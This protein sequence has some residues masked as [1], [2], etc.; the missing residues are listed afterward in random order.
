MN[1]LLEL[2]LAAVAASLPRSQQD[3]I[4]AELRDLLLTKI[5]AREAALGRALTRQEGE[6]LLNDFGHPLEVAGR[7]ARTQHLIGPAIYPFYIYGLKAVLAIVAAIGVIGLLL[8]L[9]IT[10]RGGFPVWNLAP[11]LLIA[12]AAVTLTS[13]LIE[14]FGKGVRYLRP[15]RPG[16]FPSPAPRRG[17]K[18]CN[19]L[20]EAALNAVVL[21]WWVSF[22]THTFPGVL[23]FT[24]GMR[25]VF[26][27]IWN[28]LYWPI[29]ILF[30]VQTGLNL[31][32]FLLPGRY[33][34]HAALRIAVR[35]CMV[36]VMLI[37]AQAGHWF[38]VTIPG[39]V[40]AAATL[41]T[42]IDRWLPIGIA[43][44]LLIILIETACDAWRLLR[45]AGKRQG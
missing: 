11:S 33:R 20:V 8:N 30:A 5:E 3:D 15:W 25:M 45:G 31:Y 42:Q 29:A 14:R 34:L 1:E 38:D 2:Y 27:P 24:G 17:R 37:L 18:A 23:G 40:E 6:A 41:E 32:E 16:Q 44:A 36:P 21:V 7:Y 13:A 4:I 28:Q 22:F 9:I 12:F 39:Q 43:I 19:V 10:G 35:L 26:A